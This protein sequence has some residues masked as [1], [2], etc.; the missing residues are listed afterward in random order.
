LPVFKDWSAF[1]EETVLAGGG[2]G[3]GEFWKE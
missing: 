3:K 1:G 2:T